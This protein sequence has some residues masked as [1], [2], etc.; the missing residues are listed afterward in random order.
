MAKDSNEHL[1]SSDCYRAEV[2][3]TLDAIERYGRM[4]F[5]VSVAFGPCGELGTVWS[6]SV[7]D[8]MAA[9]CFEKPFAVASFGEIANVLHDKIASRWML[10]R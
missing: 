5:V 3:K 10:A 9:D 1:G 2:H 4:G 7:M 8:V 6:V